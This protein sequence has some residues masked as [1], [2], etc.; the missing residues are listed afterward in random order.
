M[1]RLYQGAL[2]LRRADPALGDGPLHWH[3][4]PP[5]VL[6]FSRGQG[7][8]CVVNLSPHPVPLPTRSEIIL[9]SRPF[10]GG[11]PPGD[12]AAWL[13]PQQRRPVWT[14]AVYPRRHPTAS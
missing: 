7:F 1:L 9:T 6:T 10:D 3:D 4:S 11:S 12:S 14:A 13:R 2:R 8:F 5:D